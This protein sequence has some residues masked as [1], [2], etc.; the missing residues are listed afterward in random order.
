M[1]LYLFLFPSGCNI[2]NNAIELSNTAHFKQ[3][4][5]TQY[6]CFRAKTWNSYIPEARRS[7]SVFDQ[8]YSP[9][10]G[11]I[12][13]LISDITHHRF[14]RR[15]RST[16]EVNQANLVAYCPMIFSTLITTL[17]QQQHCNHA[18]RPSCINIP[19]IFIITTL[20][21]SNF[22][23]TKPESGPLKAPKFNQCSDSSE[24]WQ[25][26]FQ[27]VPFWIANPRKIETLRLGFLILMF[28][29]IKRKDCFHIS[30]C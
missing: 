30:K 17:I 15:F 13:F 5:A 22:T 11:K 23:S 29:K 9:P 10:A 14:L 20:M 7:T 28:P 21:F 2:F 6:L 24:K 8:T 1:L 26:F 19:I 18:E 25:S 4:F 12:L 3:T 16:S 27:L